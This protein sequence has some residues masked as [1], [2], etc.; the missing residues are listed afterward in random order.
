[1]NEPDGSA[2]YGDFGDCWYCDG[3]IYT[4]YEGLRGIHSDCKADSLRDKEKE[5][6]NE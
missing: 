6:P 2:I 3:A 5:T 1:M 4:D